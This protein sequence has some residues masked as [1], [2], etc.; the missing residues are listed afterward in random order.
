DYTDAA[1]LVASHGLSYDWD[2][3]NAEEKLQASIWET[4]YET[5]SGYDL[6]AGS[7]RAYDD[8]S[9][10]MTFLTLNTGND[11]SAYRVLQF[12]DVAGHFLDKQELLV[13]T[14]VPVPGAVWLLGSGLAGLVAVRR[15]PKHLPRS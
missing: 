15:R 13:K 6:T 10:D 1:R 11:L 14:V 5:G 7:F 8:Q 2:N 12:T 3:D 4:L 9:G